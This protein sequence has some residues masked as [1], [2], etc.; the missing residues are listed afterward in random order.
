MRG[1]EQDAQM[2][3]VGLEALNCDASRSDSS[4]PVELPACGVVFNEGVDGDEE[5]AVV[6]ILTSK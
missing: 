2:K 3:V 5:L 1:S 4:V 6:G